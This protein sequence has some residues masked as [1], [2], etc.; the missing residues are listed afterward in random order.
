MIPEAIILAGG[1]GTRLR[2]VIADVPK[3]MAS[4]ANKPFLTYLLLQLSKTQ[5]KKVK[6]SVGYKNEVIRQYFGNRFKHLELTYVVEKEPLWTGGGIRLA[7]EVCASDSVFVLNGDTYFDVDLKNMLNVHVTNQNGMTIALKEMVDV[8]RY[9]M[10]EQENKRIVGFS[11]K[12]IKPRT[13][14]IN[15]GIYCIDRNTFLAATQPEKFSMEVD[16]MAK[17]VDEI[18][19]MGF[20]ST[21]YFIDIGI[22][23]DYKK[24]NT[25]FEEAGF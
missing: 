23:E 19:I 16:Y 7:A 20:E 22:P 10:V 9:G 14:L 25:Y 18:A 1:M 11:E 15:G 2:S 4:V 24:A 5:V 3:P 8:T 12:S 17:R 6:L 13:G 21:G